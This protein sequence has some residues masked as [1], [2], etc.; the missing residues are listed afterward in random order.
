MPQDLLNPDL[1]VRYGSWYLRHL[2]RIYHGNPRLALAAYN[3]GQANVD[4]WIAAKQ[5]P[6]IQFSSTRQYVNDILHL[7]KLYRRAY[8]HELGYRS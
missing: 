6:L 4:S 7:Q 1:N 2:L 8:A 5:S 3:A